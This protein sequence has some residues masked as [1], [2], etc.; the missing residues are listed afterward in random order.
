MNFAREFPC[1]P[2][3]E[4]LRRAISVTFPFLGRQATTLLHAQDKIQSCLG[5]I[6]VFAHLGQHLDLV[7]RTTCVVRHLY[8]RRMLCHDDF[9]WYYR[10]LKDL[11]VLVY[12]VCVYA[13]TVS[14]G[15]QRDGVVYRST[16]P[17]P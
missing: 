5:D 2:P 4:R 11:C 16:R 13:T 12:S 3:L 6:A 17:T 8:S 14:P 1:K 7:A 9:A 15:R 10:F